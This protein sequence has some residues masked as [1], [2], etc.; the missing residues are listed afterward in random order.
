MKIQKKKNK[1]KFDARVENIKSY[2][3]ETREFRLVD[4][5]SF[6]C[7]VHPLFHSLSL[8]LTLGHGFVNNL[9]EILNRYLYDIQDRN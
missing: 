2:R 5:F 1:N 9:M 3:I 6:N 4:I 8:S 7:T